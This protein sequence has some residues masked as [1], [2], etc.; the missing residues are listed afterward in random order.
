MGIEERRIRGDG[1]LVG[2]QRGFGVLSFQH[3]PLVEAR[4]RPVR[5]LG[6]FLAFDHAQGAVG[7]IALELEQVLP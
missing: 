3:H 6:H 7:R 4:L 5:R 2:P 1:L